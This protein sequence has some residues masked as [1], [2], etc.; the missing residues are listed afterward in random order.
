MSFVQQYFSSSF[1]LSFERNQAITFGMITT[2]KFQ[3]ND[4]VMRASTI[5]HKRLLWWY[6]N[7]VAERLGY[8]TCCVLVCGLCSLQMWAKKWWRNN[9]LGTLMLLKWTWQYK[10]PL[11]YIHYGL[12][13]SYEWEHCWVLKFVFVACKINNVTRYFYLLV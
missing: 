3:G 7:K 6:K 8:K 13:V 12:L 4:C 9:S 5:E 2:R 1:Q 10:E 11:K